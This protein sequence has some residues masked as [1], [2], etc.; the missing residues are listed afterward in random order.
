MPRGGFGGG[1][2]RG[3][4]GGFGRGF[5]GGFGMRR[6]GV[7]LI[8]PMGGFGIGGS[9]LLT[10]LMAGGLG[11]MMGSNAAQ[12]NQPPPA[13][14]PYPY[15]YQAPPA[16]PQEHPSSADSGKLAQLQLLGELHENGTL[17]DDEFESQKQ[18]IL[19]G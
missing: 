19:R 2:G 7:P 5:G 13:Y 3:F 11:Y 12:Q 9:P 1:F 10:G 16:V 17:T 8:M 15:P 4:G 18:R 14:Q 6:V